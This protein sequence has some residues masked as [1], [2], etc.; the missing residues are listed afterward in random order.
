M[1]GDS[2]ILSCRGCM[3]CPSMFHSFDWTWTGKKKQVQ[4]GIDKHM[5]WK[6]FKMRTMVMMPIGNE[7]RLNTNCCLTRN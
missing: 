5:F 2:V 1:D 4:V 7:R 6:P 3:F